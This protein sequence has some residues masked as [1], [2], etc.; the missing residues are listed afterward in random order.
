MKRLN[1]VH[2]VDPLAMG[3]KLALS[4]IAM[5]AL[6]ASALA[7]DPALASEEDDSTLEE[8]SVLGSRSQARSATDSA[9]PI[10]II[11]GT[12]LHN[13]GATDV[14]DQL[15]V[16]VPSFNVSTIPID[17]AATLV[18]PANLRGLPPDNT[19]ILVN[20]KRRHR[21][22]VITFLGHGLSDGAQGVDLAVFPSLALDQVEVLRDGAAAQ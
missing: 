21:A 13:Q 5:L 2:A 1:R 15:R 19:L 4:S 16:L 17:D 12:E 3:V 8:V 11:G 9:A 6:S 7:Q 10:D 20:G 18:R 14:L 22:A